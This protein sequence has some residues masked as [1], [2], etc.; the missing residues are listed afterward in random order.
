[1]PLAAGLDEFPD[2]FPA[3]RRAKDSRLPAL[4]RN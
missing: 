1:M 4:V 2:N 3:A